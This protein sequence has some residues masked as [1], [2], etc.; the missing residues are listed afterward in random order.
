MYLDKWIRN[1]V[2]IKKK[3]LLEDCSLKSFRNSSSGINI[4]I[5]H[6]LLYDLHTL[7]RVERL[8]VVWSVKS[9]YNKFSIKMS[10]DMTQLRMCCYWV[11]HSNAA[12]SWEHGALNSRFCGYTGNWWLWKNQN[13]EQQALKMLVSIPILNLW[14]YNVKISVI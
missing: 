14:T 6:L 9:I 5:W 12:W 13:S 11:W 3:R 1:G 7:K 8:G 2:E 10:S 4:C